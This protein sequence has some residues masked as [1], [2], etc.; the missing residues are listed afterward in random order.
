MFN[1]KAMTEF[2]LFDLVS[3]RIDS[4]ATSYS[5]INGVTEARF[6]FIV[7]TT[8]VLTKWQTKSMIVTILSKS[9]DSDLSQRLCLLDA[10]MEECNIKWD[11]LTGYYSAPEPTIT[12]SY[13]DN[14][15]DNNEYR[16]LLEFFF[17]NSEMPKA[18]GV[19]IVAKD[20]CTRHVWEKT[21]LFNVESERCKYCDVSKPEI[22]QTKKENV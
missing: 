15:S 11:P 18:S 17:N 6:K 20:S 19:P 8:E 4:I 21:V 3:K 16:K 14:K 22:D 2:E 7:G 10:F 9:N 5:L 1:Y 12:T 13:M